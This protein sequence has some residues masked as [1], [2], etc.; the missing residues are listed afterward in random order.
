MEP[1]ALKSSRAHHCMCRFVLIVIE[2]LLQ[3][4]EVKAIANVLFVHLAEELVVL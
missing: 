2:H 3:S 1:P 4:V